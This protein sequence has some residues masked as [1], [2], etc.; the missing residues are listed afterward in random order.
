M[1]KWLGI[2]FGTVGAAIRCQHDLATENLALRQQLAVMK[3]QRPR[4]RLTDT[5]RV[6]W[7]LLSRICSGWRTSLHIVQP[8]TIVR[9]HRQGFRYYWRWKSRHRGRPK[10]APEIR[11]LIHRMCRGNAL[12]GAP[13]IHGELL[14]LGMEISETTVS[15]YMIK[16]Q[17]PPSQNWRIFLHNHTKELI[18]LDFFTIPT[19]TFRVLFVLLILGHNRRRNPTLQ[20]HRASDGG[21]G[22]PTA[23]G[24]V[25][26]RQYPAVPHPRSGC[27]LWQDFPA[28]GHSAQNPGC[29]D[30]T[31]L[32]LAKCVCGTS[33]WFHPPRVSQSPDRIGRTSPQANTSELRRL[34]Q[35]NSNSS[36]LK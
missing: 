9:W 29:S 28:P 3:Y 8:A 13:R 7:V 12:W 6:F 10:A 27:N 21:M 24:S 35:R 2:A 4:P 14:K 15:Q 32:T 23:P 11:A 20:R 17:G 1:I 30:R 22:S 18:A 19:A 26:D 25:W 34:L 16:R 5:D 31:S 36:V 33:D